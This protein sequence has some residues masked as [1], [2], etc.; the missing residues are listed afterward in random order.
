MLLALEKQ[1]GLWMRVGSFV[2]D[3]PP[4]SMILQRAA[5]LARPAVKTYLVAAGCVALAFLVELLCARPIGNFVSLG[6][7]YP[8][9]LVG[10]LL[11]AGPGIFAA[12]AS[13][14]LAW[15]ILLPPA[16]TLASGD[17]Q[18]VWQIVLFT[19]STGLIIAVAGAFR[20]VQVTPNAANELFKTVQDISS[21]G[22]VIY[23]ALRDASG[24]AID[25]EYRYANPAA[26]AFMTKSDPNRV[27]GG[28]LLERLP[29]ARE[30]P[31]LFPRYLE[32]LETGNTSEAEYEL[33]GR[34]F[35]SKVAK[36]QDGLVVTMRDVSAQHRSDEVQRLLAQELDHRVKNMLTTVIS[37]T[38][39]TANGASSVTELRDKLLGR[40]QAMGRAHELLVA[41][42]WTD[43]QVD[44]VVRGTLD[45]RL[46]SNADRFVI[47]GPEVAIE[48]ETALALNMA[49]HEL[50]TNAIKYGALSADRGQVEISWAQDAQSPSVIHL[51]WIERGGPPVEKPIGKGFGTRLLE[52]AFASLEGSRV[53]LHH[54]RS[55][56]HCEIVFNA[57]HNLPGLSVSRIEMTNSDDP[58]LSSRPLPN[59]ARAG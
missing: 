44:E 2:L 57:K 21:E 52:R 31:Q 46:H 36:L 27:V 23:R 4:L 38:K 26:L 15:L 45:P 33:G 43:A 9:V 42:S 7:F 56:V 16:F 41:S 19:L 51:S 25:L 53:L 17:A 49:L 11:G 48:P 12:L 20:K 29:L 50:A 39:L 22:L 1:Y 5:N 6:A 13:L 54:A 55:G 32:V 24:R 35:R 3:I 28:R 14:L 58:P 40:F 30:H 34:R 47:F 18:E 59:T 37:M 8:A 10:A